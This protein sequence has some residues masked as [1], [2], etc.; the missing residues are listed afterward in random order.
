MAIKSISIVDANNGWTSMD[1]G[2]YYQFLPPH[3]EARTRT[4]I[5]RASP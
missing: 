5:V 3:K 2:Y 4:C 1:P